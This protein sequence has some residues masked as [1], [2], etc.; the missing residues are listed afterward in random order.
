[1]KNIIIAFLFTFCA[2]NLAGQKI[3]VLK[4]GKT[5][6]VSPKSAEDNIVSF[7]KDSTSLQDT[8]LQ[9]N[10]FLLEKTT[11][12]LGKPVLEDSSITQMKNIASIL[13]AYPKLKIAIGCHSDVL[14]SK[15]ANIMLTQ[16][17]ADAYKKY[18]ILQGVYKTKITEAI[19]YGSKYASHKSG[20]DYIEL[21]KD[22]KLTLRIVSF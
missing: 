11:F 22:R 20:S 19:G 10:W 17:R 2:S 12:I 6:N 5:L 16:A 13:I 21:I 18:L 15:T 4:N 8:S 9:N 3:L 7:L 1:M 14:G